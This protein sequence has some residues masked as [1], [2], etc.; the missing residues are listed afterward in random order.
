MTLLEPKAVTKRNGVFSNFQSNTNSQI[1]NRELLVAVLFKVD[2]G[3]I[4][5]RAES[6]IPVHCLFQK[7]RFNMSSTVFRETG[8]HCV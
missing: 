5:N 2:D 1:I 4:G 3:T 8:R 6:V 7:I